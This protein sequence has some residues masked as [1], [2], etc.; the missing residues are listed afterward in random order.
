[1]KRIALAL[2]LTMLGVALV[3]S[4]QAKEAITRLKVCGASQCRTIANLRTLEIL[5]TEIGD[6]SVAPP[7]RGPF[8]TMRPEKTRE[9]PSTWPHYVYVP[10]S[11]SVRV[12][13]GNGDRYWDRVGLSA[14][15]L[16]RV[17]RNLDPNRTP[18]AWSTTEVPLRVSGE[19]HRVPR[20]TWFAGAGLAVIVVSLIAQRA[21][22][23]RHEP[24][25]T[26]P[27]RH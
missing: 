14:D 18:K 9:W 26:A 17:T 1:M 20:W 4:A 3:P 19:P 7:A 23:L 2:G 16:R 13:M 21:R 27:G 15:L 12:T 6:E 22:Q 25:V 10:S 5:M 24:P 8:Y 11:N